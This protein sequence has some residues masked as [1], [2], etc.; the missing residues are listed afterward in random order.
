MTKRNKVILFVSV[1]LAI[2]V[3]ASV[4][5][6]LRYNFSADSINI[7]S[8]ILITIIIL[9]SIISI[10]VVYFSKVRKSK[11]EAMLNN[12]Y[13]QKYEIIK[14]AVMNS[15][16]S[17]ISKN[18]IMED[19]LDMLITA[20]KSGKSADDTVGNPGSFARNILL[21]YY[22]PG[23]LPVLSLI[24]G[25]IY[26]I[27][28]IL[29]A[30]IFL[31]FEQSSFG[32]FEIG[33]DISMLIFFFLICFI[34]IPVTKK[35]IST[36][37]YWVFILPVA[38]GIVFILIAE[39]V[40]RFFYNNEIIRLLLDGTVRMIPNIFLLILYIILIPALLLLKSYIR[41]RLLRSID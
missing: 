16:L 25:A 5:L 29:G 41:K 3:I 22:K 17:N 15:Q 36:K 23:R 11:F 30:S 37:N 28:F 19:M 39:L 35:Y 7:R 18:E 38:S 26:F 20:Q 21:A 6:Y 32:L 10:P 4:I 2:C 40:R 31:W 27:A 33:I 24:D 12:E 1:F 34:I 14:D 8:L 13:F 9:L